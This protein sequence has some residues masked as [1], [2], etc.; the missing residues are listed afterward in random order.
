[1][2]Y[3]LNRHPKLKTKLGRR[4]DWEWIN[5]ATPENI[6]YLFDLYVTV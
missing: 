3:F 5:M 6:M 4:T 1:M 2:M